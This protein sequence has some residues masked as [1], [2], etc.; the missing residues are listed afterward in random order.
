[1][2]YPLIVVLLLTACSWPS[3]APK[4]ASKPNVL[5]ISV[6][7]LRA[8]RL[9]SHGYHLPT[10]PTLDRLAEQGVRFDDA[11][12]PWPVTWPAMASMLTGT[13]PST[14]GMRLLPRRPLPSDNV[15]LAE[16]LREAGYGTGAVVA[17]V[18]VGRKFAFDQGF[19]HFVESWATEATRQTGRPDFK[20]RPGRVKAFTNATI[21]TDEAIELLNTFEEHQPFF[22]WLHYI[23]PHGPYLPPPPYQGL[24]HD[25]YAPN[26]LREGRLPKY[27]R[28]LDANGKPIRDLAHYEA[29]YDREIR[30]FDD[31]LQRLLADLEHRGLVQNTLMIVT[32]DHGESLGEHFDYLNHGGTPHQP[33]VGVPLIVVFPGRVPV[34]QEVSAPVGLIDLTPTVLDLVGLDIPDEIQGQSLA[35]VMSG[36]AG[37]HEFVF[38]ESGT[39]SPTQLSVR[40]GKW[41]LVQI[42]A[43]GDRKAFRLGESQLYDLETD[44]TEQTNV[45]AAHR[46]IVEK[47]AAALAQW[48]RD[49]P[50]YHGTEG[51]GQKGLDPQ[52]KEMLRALGYAE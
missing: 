31:Q 30:Y 48:K 45:S 21:V 42:R 13:Y 2:R 26:I 35:A 16:Y 29:Q 8:D 12:V 23:D 14:N 49:T 32:A 7:T 1:M 6:D 9:G 17:N 46:A 36:A 38:M 50:V 15:T 47:L 5:L 22:L 43:P 52:T 3:D 51:M 24:W 25:Q 34:G 41:K 39:R 28:Q 33:S 20:N 37:P 11:S 44:P 27:Q 40:H 10:S 19:D 18:N 4:P